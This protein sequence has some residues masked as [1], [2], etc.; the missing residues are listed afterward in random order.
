L[1]FGARLINSLFRVMTLLGL[2]ASYRHILTVR[3]RKTG[4]LYSTPVDVLE[5]DGDRWLVAGYGHTNWVRN[6]R[7][8]GEVTLSRG[9][10]SQKFKVDEVCDQTAVPA[11]KVHGRDSRNAAVLRRQ[12]KL[13][14]SGSRRR[15]RKA[16]RLSPDPVELTALPEGSARARPPSAREVRGCGKT[17]TQEPANP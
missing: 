15:A 11:P 5:L 17:R 10:Q 4:R 12:S 13:V 6:A 7:A 9:R 2:E 14:R 16:C 3:G 1:N 8:A